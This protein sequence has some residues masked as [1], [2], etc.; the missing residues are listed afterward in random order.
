MRGFWKGLFKVVLA[1]AVVA[2]IVIAVLRAFFVDVVTV[3][4]NGMAPTMLLGDR[5][6]VWRG[7]HLD[8]NDIVLCRHAMQPDRWV[9]GRI[10]A[11]PGES[12]SVDGRGQLVVG[13]SAVDR[14][15]Q[16]RGHFVDSETGRGYPVMWG[17]EQFS[18]YQEHRFFD[19]TDRRFTMR[20]QSDIGGVFLLGDNRGH[21]GEDSRAFGVVS[22]ETCRGQ[23]FMRLSAADGMPEGIPHGNLDILD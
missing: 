22:P 13:G 3:A 20:A 11:L 1:L 7:A 10:A 23:V 14:D 8:R 18:D 5:V 4:H 12:L 2:A 9:M 6:L 16:G 19:R 17:I 21:H 15:I